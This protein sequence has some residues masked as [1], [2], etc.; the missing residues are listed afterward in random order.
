V[1]RLTGFYRLR[2]GVHADHEIGCVAVDIVGIGDGFAA[3]LAPS[4]PLSWPTG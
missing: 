4:T 1:A 2:L 3:L